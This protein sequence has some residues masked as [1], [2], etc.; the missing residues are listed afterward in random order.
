MWVI[1]MISRWSW[2]TRCWCAKRKRQFIHGVLKGLNVP[3][4][5]ELKA[6]TVKDLVPAVFA[7]TCTYSVNAYCCAN[8]EE[9]Q[10]NKESASQRKEMQLRHEGLQEGAQAFRHDKPDSWEYAL[11]V[12]ESCWLREFRVKK[13]SCRWNF[14]QS[15]KHIM[16]S[17]FE[18][19][20]MCC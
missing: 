11:N 10:A 13:L 2:S 9:S 7:R 3:V 1:C 8:D 6:T 14:C 5:R 19:R 20:S 17:E 4:C 18:G 15:S 16:S 12:A